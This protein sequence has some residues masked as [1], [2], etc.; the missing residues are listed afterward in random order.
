MH[1]CQEVGV[2]LGFFVWFFSLLDS[3]KRSLKGSEEEE[4]KDFICSFQS[5]KRKIFTDG[6]NHEAVFE[7]CPLISLCGR[8][9]GVGVCC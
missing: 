1:V 3:V 2:E 7:P 5:S 8:G 9:Q 4:K 6:E